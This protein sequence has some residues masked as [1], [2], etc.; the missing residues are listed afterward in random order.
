MVL[1]TEK[2]LDEAYVM[3]VR[4]CHKIRYAQAI[5]IQ[6]PDREEFRREIFEPG[7]EEILTDEFWD[8]EE[9]G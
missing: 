2:Q 6:I 4:G 1:Y 7:W 5:D 8:E 3:F 9:D